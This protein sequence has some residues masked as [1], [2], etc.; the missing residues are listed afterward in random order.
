MSWL[1]PKDLSQALAMLDDC[2]PAIVCGGTDL[3]VNSQRRDA[4]WKNKTWMDIRTL[5]ELR[6]IRLTGEG[7]ELGSAVTAA[8]LWQHPLGAK[9]PALQQA[10]RIVGGWQIQNRASI[11]GN[12]ANASPA[13]DM[14]VPLSAYRSVIRLRSSEGLRELP[15]DEFILGPRKTALQEGELIESVLIPARML[16][17]PQ[18]FLRH[19]QRGATDISIVSVAVVLKGTSDGPI[20]WGER[21]AW[22]SAAVGAA[23]PVPLALPEVDAEWAGELTAEKADRISGRYMELSRPISDVRAS[24]DYRQA[25]VRVFM[26]RAVKR[27]AEGQDVLGPQSMRK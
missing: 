6:Q 3:F 27:I 20:A 24:Q 1:R 2:R 15:V 9:V 26:N 22:G 8:E 25:M 5:P 23:N 16:D 10:A 18:M 7:L 19:D 4:E 13:A 17:T 14:V 12:L 11:G 21:L